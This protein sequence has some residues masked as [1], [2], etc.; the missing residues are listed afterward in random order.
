M[1][2]N[3]IF[4]GNSIMA[5]EGAGNSPLSDDNVSRAAFLSQ[6]FSSKSGP[7]IRVRG[8]KAH[9]INTSVVSNVKAGLRCPT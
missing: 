8:S 4:D 6:S 7:R 3:V 1:P 5:C 9:E 2:M